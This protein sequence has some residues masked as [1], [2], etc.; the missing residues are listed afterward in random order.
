MVAR[1]GV[2]FNTRLFP[3][4]DLGRDTWNQ[5]IHPPRQ[6]LEEHRRPPPTPTSG[7]IFLLFAQGW[8]FT[9]WE[10]VSSSISSVCITCFLMGFW[11]GALISSVM[12]L[13]IWKDLLMSE[14]YPL[15]QVSDFPLEDGATWPTLTGGLGTAHCSPLGHGLHPLRCPSACPPTGSSQLSMALSSD[16]ERPSEI[17]PWSLNTPSLFGVLFD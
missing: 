2:L 12:Y 13:Q 6:G 10:T 11:G 16:Q 1:Y 3:E 17:D 9:G 15:C 7:Y 5:G 8:Y 14:S 4:E